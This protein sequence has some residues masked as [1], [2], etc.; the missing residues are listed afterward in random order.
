[1]VSVAPYFYTEKLVTLSKLYGIE[2]EYDDFWGKKHQ[3]S[4]EELINILKSMGVVIKTQRDIEL[5]ILK[6]KIRNARKHIKSVYVFNES[7]KELEICINTKLA[8]KNEEIWNTLTWNI[9]FEKG[10]SISH[11]IKRE[12]LKIKSESSLNNK[13]YITYKFLLTEKIPLGYHTLQIKTEKFECE[14]RI[15]MSPISCY[16]PPCFENK[17]FEKD[18]ENK[19][20]WGISTQLY[21]LRSYWN[22][23]I[24]DFSDLKKVIN[25]ASQVNASLI[26]I[27]PLHAICPK[28]IRGESPY[29]PTSRNALEFL[30]LDLGLTQEF[31]DSKEIQDE[32]LKSD[33]QNE[34]KSLQGANLVE[35]QRL[36]KLKLQVLKLLF[37]V[38]KNNHLGKHTKREQDF[39]NFCK[40][41]LGAF[42][43][44][45]F[46][47]LDSVFNKDNEN[48]QG[49]FSWPEE[50]KDPS[51]S[52]VKEFIKNNSDSINF[53]LYIQ[54]LADEQLT[55]ISNYSKEK[56]LTLGIYLDLALG[57]RKDGAES[58][59]NQDIVAKNINIGAPPDFYN[60]EGQDWNIG[61]WDPNK[62]Q[63]KAYKP[64]I[65][66]LRDQMKYADVLRID[67][68]MSLMRL[69]WIPQGES[70]KNGVYVKY[71]LEDLMGIVALESH[72]NKCLIIGEDMG[73]VPPEIRKQMDKRFM[74]SYKV[75][76]FEKEN[77]T[78]FKAP[79]KYPRNAVVVTSVHDTPPLKG[80]WYA[81]D[82]SVRR[83]I[84]VYNEEI[85]EKLFQLRKS[86]R[87]TLSVLLKTENIYL[88][89]KY[90]NGEFSKEVNIA[91]HKLVAKTPCRLMLTTIDD[92]IASEELMNLPG[93][94][95]EYPNWR[96]KLTIPLE[97]VIDK[98]DIR[99]ISEAIRS[100]G[101]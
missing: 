97:E 61:C 44:A 10:N 42:T 85:A 71:P 26:G 77:D 83:N 70:A 20:F 47:S 66:L 34:L 81:K 79:K 53:Y 7:Q 75:L 57:A 28:D 65:R 37:N 96:S 52:K 41:N 6:F 82:I 16:I 101:R 2:T 49:F 59:A 72:R 21:S 9:I 50:Y 86:E 94:Y 4:K 93:T 19:R 89:E 55:N 45:L 31:Q 27:N 88:P 33:F 14:T 39:L 22:W 24:G 12:D 74:L 69:Y 40:E 5:A 11:K 48:S 30:Y 23:G 68:V 8:E 32:I 67:H 43:Y 36:K 64:Y 29:Y 76:M 51:S 78:E 87:E 3:A 91:L 46:E 58:W 60:F 35:Y 63:N 18:N 98:S 13:K 84:G 62:L 38:F 1:M 25:I 56:K 90:I 80:F 73:L 54:F 17:S 100:E 92:L 95:E 99:E 15:I